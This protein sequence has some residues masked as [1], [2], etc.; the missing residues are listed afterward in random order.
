MQS[1]TLMSCLELS[2]KCFWRGNSCVITA[3]L[4]FAQKNSLYLE[5]TRQANTLKN[6]RKLEFS[7]CIVTLFQAVP[8]ILTISD[9]EMLV[10]DPKSFLTK[11]S[12]DLGD[13]QRISVSPLKD[14]VIVFHIRTVRV[15]SLCFLLF[16]AI[17][18]TKTPEGH[19]RIKK[20]NTEIIG[21]R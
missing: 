11:Y 7:C 16:P 9:S 1:R 10:L 8:H 5:R 15:A 20:Y 21:R 6:T 12:V 17:S 14:G 19:Q 3:S 4:T 2:R 13:I 18:M